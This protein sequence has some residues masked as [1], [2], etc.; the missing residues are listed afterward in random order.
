MKFNIQMTVDANVNKSEEVELA[1]VNALLVFSETIN[2][3]EEIEV[4]RESE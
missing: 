3:V 2:A 4:A 1:I